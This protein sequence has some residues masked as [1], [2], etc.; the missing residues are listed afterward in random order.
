M[1]NLYAEDAIFDVSAVFS[2]VAPMR[3]H[4]AMLAYWNELRETWGRGI[5]IDPVEVLDV[6]EWRYV[7]EF[8]LSATG[9][10]SGAEV[11]DT[12]AYLYEL[13]AEDEKITRA[14]MFTDAA[15]AIRAAT[16]SAASESD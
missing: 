13:R 8:R 11:A 2:D 3:G 14:R 4:D 7:V 12:L 10:L 6:G 16:P 5:R 15:T 1:L 9:S